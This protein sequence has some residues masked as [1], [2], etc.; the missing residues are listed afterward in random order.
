[1][2]GDLRRASA[3]IHACATTLSS[4]TSS[5]RKGSTYERLID[6]L[7]T[8]CC[9]SL[10]TRTTGEQRDVVLETL[11]QQA[12]AHLTDSL[13]RISVDL[14]HICD[15]PASAIRSGLGHAQLL[16]D[17]GRIPNTP[18]GRKLTRLDQLSQAL[19]TLDR[20]TLSDPWQHAWENAERTGTFDETVAE[21]T[22]SVP[23]A[24]DLGWALIVFETHKHTNLI[25]HQANK[26]VRSFPDRHA[27]DLLGWGWLGLRV[28]L[29]HYDPTLGFTFSTYAC[30]RIIGSIRDGVR[31]ENP[32][33]KRLNTFTRKVAAAEAELTQSLGRSPSLEEVSERIGVELSALDIL[34]RTAPQASVDEL[35]GQADERGG[36]LNRLV[37]GDDPA[38]SALASIEA[39]LVAEA[40][41]Q[42]NPDDAL[43][44]KLLVMDGMNPTEARAVTGATARQ[45]RQR[46]ERG[47][48]ALRDSLTAWHETES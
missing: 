11:T 32:I 46:K 3:A 17:N 44:V 22:P 12:Q 23:G 18:A 19:V 14:A 9:D 10:T 26:L 35:L 31:S 45:L 2:A 20:G 42:L 33:P 40:L 4:A 7:T 38:D 13:N 37:S 27:S 6:Q 24:G 39:D 21:L 30:S 8:A 28:A 34:P 15:M 41:A 16:D 29:R 36:Y 25:W 1:M 43:A 47:L 48:A 5:P